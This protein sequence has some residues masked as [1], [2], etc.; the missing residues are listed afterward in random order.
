MGGR[1]SSGAAQEGKESEI[2]EMKLVAIYLGNYGIFKDQLLSFSADYKV[3]HNVESA[4]RIS[5]RIEHER[6]L[7]DR[8]FSLRP[9]IGE[10]VS[11]VV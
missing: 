2:S 3:I 4:D 5:F 10:C 6:M 9:Y 7:P 11:S 8:F 1:R